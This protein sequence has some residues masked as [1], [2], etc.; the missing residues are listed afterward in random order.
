[1]PSRGRRGHLVA[2][3]RAAGLLAGCGTGGPDNPAPSPSGSV[4]AEVSAD[5]IADVL[6]N[7][8]E[9]ETYF[10]MDRSTWQRWRQDATSMPWHM[11]SAAGVEQAATCIGQGAPTVVYRPLIVLQAGVVNASSPLPDDHVPWDAS[12]RQAATISDN[13][14]YAVIDDSDHAIPIRNPGAVVAATTAVADSIRA[15]NAD[16]SACPDD[17]AAAGVTCEGG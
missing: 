11:V 13:S 6:P 1:M 2:P 3:I 15:G 17:L 16:L 12:Q 7:D 10:D 14:V 9:A 4:G 8:L 5:A